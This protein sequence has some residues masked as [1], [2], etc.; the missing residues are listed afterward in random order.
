LRTSLDGVAVYH[1]DTAVDCTKE[2]WA[3]SVLGINAVYEIRFKSDKEG[4]ASAVIPTARSPYISLPVPCTLAALAA[5]T[6]FAALASL[7]ALAALTALA[8]LAALGI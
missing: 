6:T 5:L 7:A 2:D 3:K 8:A 1:E 4:G